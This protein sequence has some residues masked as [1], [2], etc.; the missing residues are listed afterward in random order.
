MMTLGQ[1]VKR[2]RIAKGW[3]LRRLERETERHG[4]KVSNAYISQLENDEKYDIN[5]SIATVEVLA[6]ALG[7]SVV[8]LLEDE[9]EMMPFVAEDARLY[10]LSEIGARIFGLSKLRDIDLGEVA[11]KSGC[12]IRDIQHIHD[13]NPDLAMIQR[14]A[15]ALNTTMHY[16]LG[17]TDDPAPLPGL[18][19]AHHDP[20]SG[21][22][23]G[24]PMPPETQL[25]V[26]R[27][28]MKA[29]EEWGWD[30]APEG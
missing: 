15:S 13:E 6:K 22:E 29:K 20:E 4:R 28:I 21:V 25:I 26:E 14:L 9:S 17:R 3:S 8:Y 11:V 23:P 30:K 19:V 1:K 27:A 12:S 7:V 16:L 2:L 5:P 10:G 18:A 24:D